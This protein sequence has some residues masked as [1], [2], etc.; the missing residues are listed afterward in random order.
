MLRGAVYI[1]LLG[2]GGERRAWGSGSGLPELP[3]IKSVLVEKVSSVSGVDLLDRWTCSSLLSR[4]AMMAAQKT[5]RAGSRSR[6]SAR[7]RP[8]GRLKG[9]ASG[10]FSIVWWTTRG[11]RPPPV[12]PPSYAAA[13]TLGTRPSASPPG[14]L[15]PPP[16]C[17][18]RHAERRAALPLAH[19]GPGG[20]RRQARGRRH[21][22]G[23]GGADQV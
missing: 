4:V 13:W 8:A 17:R 21:S 22:H 10:S 7:A 9:H 2:F 19:L 15:T 11:S 6:P 23:A 1:G 16:A 5:S 20:G 3:Q 12:R 14:G 18:G